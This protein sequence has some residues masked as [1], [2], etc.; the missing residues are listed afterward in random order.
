[1]EPNADSQGRLRAPCRASFALHQG[2]AAGVVVL[3][4]TQACGVAG[5]SSVDNER[6]P[7]V[8][9]L[10]LLYDMAFPPSTLAVSAL[11]WW[12]GYRGQH[13]ALQLVAVFPVE[14]C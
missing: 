12:A 10:W 9:S 8:A 13:R 1:M 11:Y 2:G 14:G 4:I 6:H 7:S 3:H 5:H